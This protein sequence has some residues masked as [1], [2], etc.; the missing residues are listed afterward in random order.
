MSTEPLVAHSLTEAYLYLKV[1]KCPACGRGIL[2]GEGQLRAERRDTTSIVT[3]D[4]ICAACGAT[5]SHRFRVADGTNA[6]PG[7]DLGV[8]NPTDQPSRIIDVAQWITLFR[9]LSE[10][11]AQDSDRVRAR[12]V[13]IEAGQCL[14]EALKFYDPAEGDLPPVSACFHDSSR[15]RLRDHPEQFSRTRLIELRRKLPSAASTGST[16]ADRPPKRWRRFRR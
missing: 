5:G 8:I 2:R 7:D 9:M 16:P 14:E 1:T 13:R 3:I 10:I 4:S 12:S 11:A 6:R 15:D